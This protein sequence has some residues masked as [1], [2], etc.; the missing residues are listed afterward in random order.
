MFENDD[1]TSIIKYCNL[2]LITLIGD[3]VSFVEIATGHNISLLVSNLDDNIVISWQILMNMKVTQLKELHQS[4]SALK[5]T[6][7]KEKEKLIDDILKKHPQAIQ[8]VVEAAIASNVGPSDPA[9]AK[10]ALLYPNSTNSDI[11]KYYNDYYGFIH[12]LD[13]DFYSIMKLIHHTAWRKTYLYSILMVIVQNVWIL[14]EK[15]KLQLHKSKQGS[16]WI[17]LM[18]GS[19]DI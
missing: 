5:K 11:I 10:Q 7:V 9:A 4:I 6:Q 18:R 15:H 8:D 13:K 12:K 16:F 17:N 14:W 19:V 2:P 1:A 3:M